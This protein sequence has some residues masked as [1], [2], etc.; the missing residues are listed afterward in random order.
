MI[1]IVHPP[2]LIK[3]RAR[4]NLAPVARPSNDDF[5]EAINSVMGMLDAGD[6]T[7][8]RQDGAPVDTLLPGQ[9]LDEYLIDEVLGTGGFGVTYKAWDTLLET[10]VAIKEYFPSE[11]SF[12]DGDGVTVHPNTQGGFRSID[13]QLSNYLWG[14]ERFLE[15]ARVLARVQHPY[16]VRVKR[17][18]R[19]HGTAYI[20]MDY[21]EGQPLS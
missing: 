8:V 14:L 20:V 13:E 19:A 7:D 21:E 2:S 15:E 5:V 10:W 4:R 3:S 17:Y 16:V 18:F 6:A 12:R 9:T 11:W 1:D